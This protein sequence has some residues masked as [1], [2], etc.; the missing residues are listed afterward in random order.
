[1]AQVSKERLREALEG[2]MEDVAM[3]LGDSMTYQQ[4]LLAVRQRCAEVW[5]M[6]ELGDVPDFEA[7]VRVRKV[8]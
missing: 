5:Q 4:R 3:A 7:Q 8:S 6:A 1:M 2:A